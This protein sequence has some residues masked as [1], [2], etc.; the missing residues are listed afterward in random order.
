[1]PSSPTIRSLIAFLV[2]GANVMGKPLPASSGTSRGQSLGHRPQPD[3]DRRG[4]HDR[5]SGRQSCN[6]LRR[7]AVSDS[8]TLVHTKQAGGV[9]RRAM[10]PARQRTHE[11][12]VAAVAANSERV[13]QARDIAS[14]ACV[15]VPMPLGR[16][17]CE[18]HDGAPR[19]IR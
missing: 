8:A 12:L 15:T 1:M 5:P 6:K 14:S 10:C 13:L 2:A 7:L 17:S 16:R 18:R 19:D 4:A 9:A 3:R 11:A